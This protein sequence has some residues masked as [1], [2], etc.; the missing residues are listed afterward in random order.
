MSTVTSKARYCSS[1]LYFGVPDTSQ[2]GLI[3]TDGYANYF[4]VVGPAGRQLLWSSG[5]NSPITTFYDPATRQR[6]GAIKNRPH[7]ERYLASPDGSRLYALQHMLSVPT[8]ARKATATLPGT[9]GSQGPAPILLRVYDAVSFALLATHEIDIPAHSVSSQTMLADGRLRALTRLHDTDELLATKTALFTGVLT[10]DPATGAVTHEPLST[11]P[12]DTEYVAFSPSGKYLLRPDFSTFGFWKQSDS[13]YRWLLSVQLWTVEP[14]QLLRVLPVVW[15]NVSDHKIEL[16]HAEEIVAGLANRDPALLEC[17]VTYSQKHLFQFNE[18]HQITWQPDEAAFWMRI[19]NVLACVGLDDSVSPRIDIADWQPVSI[20][21][22]GDRS[23]RLICLTEKLVTIDVD[24]SPGTGKRVVGKKGAHIKAHGVGPND[25]GLYAQAQQMEAEHNTLVV[26]LADKSEGA[27][28]QAIGKLAEIFEAD[29]IAGRY[30]DQLTFAFELKGKRITD[31]KFFGDVAKSMP[32]A[33][34]VMKRMVEAF[35]AMSDVAPWED[36]DTVVAMLKAFVE[37]VPDGV[38]ILVHPSRRFSIDG[39]FYK[40]ILPLM[41]EKC[42]WRPAMIEYL[43]TWLMPYNRSTFFSTY[44]TRNK[45]GAAVAEASTPQ[46]FAERYVTGTFTDPVSSIVEIRP[47][48]KSRAA[49]WRDRT[50]WEDEMVA[51]VTA[52]LDERWRLRSEKT[53]EAA[54]V[55]RMMR[56]FT[57][58]RDT[59]SKEFAQR[60]KVAEVFGLVKAARGEV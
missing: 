10:V 7:V 60:P 58:G 11:R 35:Y 56:T 40:A 43:M 16:K 28:I 38:D 30:T 19:E 2:T 59:L 9:N 23:A 6:A 51:A 24:G 5:H 57:S 4:G 54:A 18:I 44:W 22:T 47:E 52:I 33:A 49:R 27:Y 41:I 3:A 48:W 45:L 26:P 12:N 1:C 42:G 13:N 37:L 46:Q 25:D 21:P 29:E 31:K 34:P 53:V 32:A 39:R 15:L 14:M 50:P 20:E 17:A 8:P 36:R 55:D